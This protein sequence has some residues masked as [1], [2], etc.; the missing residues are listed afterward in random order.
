MRK[1]IVIFLMCFVSSFSYAQVKLKEDPCMK[2]YKI[3]KENCVEFGIG[4]FSRAIWGDYYYYEKTF[5]T[6]KFDYYCN[7]AKTPADIIPFEQFK[8]EVCKTGDTKTKGLIPQKQK[9]AKKQP[10][11]EL[12]TKI[13]KI[14]LVITKNKEDQVSKDAVIKYKNKKIDVCGY[15]FLD[16]FDGD[17][18]QVEDINVY[19][20][21]YAVGNA[22]EGGMLI[23]D[24]PTGLFYTHNAKRIDIYKKENNTIKFFYKEREGEIYVFTYTNGKMY[25]STSE[26]KLGN[27]MKM[28]N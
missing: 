17:Y 4:G 11:T 12:D 26:K 28:L 2:M 9:I 24:T 1:V 25:E 14:S 18:Y 13:G 23:F 16:G 10:I 3:Y 19:S 8:K 5:D 22:M 15:C 21:T 27:L 6:K 20:I 7:S